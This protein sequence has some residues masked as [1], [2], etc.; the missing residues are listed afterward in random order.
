M[1]NCTKSRVHSTTL[2]MILPTSSLSFIKIHVWISSPLSYT[3]KE[4]K[5]PFSSFLCSY[6][7]NHFH[8]VDVIILHLVKISTS[9]YSINLLRILW[10]FVA[11][12]NSFT[13]TWVHGWR[14]NLR[15]RHISSTLKSWVPGAITM[16][17]GRSSLFLKG[18]GDMDSMKGDLYWLTLCHEPTPW[19]GWSSTPKIVLPNWTQWGRGNSS[20]KGMLLGSENCY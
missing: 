15:N 20:L 12:A 6:I 10:F 5:S 11:K 16:L 7:K 4:N 18:L 1:Q 3:G 9:R 2:S 8:F 17:F 14:P 19:L 13:T